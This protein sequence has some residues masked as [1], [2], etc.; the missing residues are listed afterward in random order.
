MADNVLVTI[1]ISRELNDIRGKCRCQRFLT[2]H[3]NKT[4]FV[5]VI[6]VSTLPTMSKSHLR[7]LTLKC[8]RPKLRTLDQDLLFGK[9]YTGETDVE[10][11]SP[12]RKQASV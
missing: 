5:T 12:V 10:H 3:S 9:A 7:H 1:E 4:I 11:Q 8:F 2:D 6:F